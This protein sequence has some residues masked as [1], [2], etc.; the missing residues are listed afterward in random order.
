[1]DNASGPYQINYY[2]WNPKLDW[3]P[4]DFDATHVFKIWGVYQPDFFKQ[5]WERKVLGGW[6]I[7]GIFNWHSGFPWSPYY[8]STCNLIYQNG[9]CTNGGSTQLAPVSYLGGASNDYS[10]S[11]F[12]RGGGNFQ[13]GSLT[14]FTAPTFTNCAATFPAVCPGAPQ[15][16]GIQRNNFRGPRYRDVDAT[17]SKAFGLPKMP[18]LGE[19]A[20]FEFR[21]NFYNLFNNLNLDVAQIDK[22]L[23]SWD[24]TSQSFIQNKTFGEITGSPGALAGRTIELQAR[25]SF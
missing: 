7:S 2:Q 18:I 17:I 23:G 22:T 13:N 11:A 9:A 10:N 20:Q 1:M 12:L 8:N 24:T 19:N 5:G 16:P 6:S 21:A 3:G 25:F 15:A 4:S 14:Y